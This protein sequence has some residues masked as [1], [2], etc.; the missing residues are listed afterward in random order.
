M[1]VMKDNKEDF[2]KEDKFSGLSF[3][4]FCWAG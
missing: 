1:P 4:C 2:E 3:F